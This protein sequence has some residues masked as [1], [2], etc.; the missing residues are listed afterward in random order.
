MFMIN[1]SYISETQI[2]LKD[3]ED[4]SGP[5]G[6]SVDCDPDKPFREPNG[7]C[8]NLA[9]PTWGSAGSC[10]RRERSWRFEHALAL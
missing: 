10:L 4:S 1:T 8:N 6:T 5:C 3:G 2:P 9:H 7:T